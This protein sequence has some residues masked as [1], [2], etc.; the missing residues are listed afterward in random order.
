M[1][2]MLL[3]FL[4]AQLMSSAAFAQAD[5]E[6]LRAGKRQFRTA[7][8]ACHGLEKGDNRNSGPTLHGLLGRKA[9]TQPDFAFSDVMKSS[10]IVWSEETLDQFLTNPQEAIPGNKMALGAVKVPEQRAQI[11]AYLK[12]ETGTP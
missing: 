1:K 4:S 7:C 5:E 3:A 10:P 6:T 2:L 8:Q 11:I 12:S 9:G